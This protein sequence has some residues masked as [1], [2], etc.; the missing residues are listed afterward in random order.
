MTVLEATRS[1]PGGV[2]S[3]AP[4]RLAW[5]GT[6]LGAV[7][8]AAA[9]WFAE[10]AKVMA[11]LRNVELRWLGATFV[12]N[13]AQ[14]SLLGLRWTRVAGLLGVEISWAHATRECALSTALNQVLPLGALGDGLRALREA[15]RRDSSNWAS[16]LEAMVLDR[17]SSQLGLWLVVILGLPWT[18]HVLK[19]SAAT[20]ASSGSGLQGAVV[21]TLL[22]GAGLTCLVLVLTWASRRWRAVAIGVAS[23]LVRAGRVL[24][25]FRAAL[26]HLPLS[27]LLVALVLLQFD[28]AARAIGVRLPLHQLL[29]LVPLLLVASSLPSAIGGVGLREVASAVLFAGAGVGSSTGVAVCVV[30]GAFAVLVSLP[31]LMVLLP[32]MSRNGA[33]SSSQGG[34]LNAPDTRLARLTW[35]NAHAGLML[36]ATVLTLWTGSLWLVACCAGLSFCVLVARSRS[37]WTPRGGFGAANWITATRAV[38]TLALPLI[39]LQLEGT[40]TAGLVLAALAMAVLALDILDGWVARRF[41]VAGEFGATFDVEADAVFVLLLSLLLHERGVAGLWV[42]GAGLWRYV[43]VLAPL[44]VATVEP[45]ATRSL[46]GRAAYVVLIFSLV[47]ALLL[48][49]AWSVLVAAFG[50]SAVSASFLLSFWHRYAAAKPPQEG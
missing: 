49:P 28:F 29:G 26:R 36:F 41:A 15:R 33:K 21:L 12:L 45:P 27:L 32:T 40:S 35:M 31:G 46:F 3:R 4:T 9:L 19:P 48:P 20:P 1:A 18:W 44:L 7:L 34:E 5:L 2:A 43:Y 39:H 25:T 13:L 8:F 37:K 17:I 11:Q 42:V 10:P 23:R 30:F 38:V 22:V 47:L 50:T 6:A 16:A 14:L 24:F